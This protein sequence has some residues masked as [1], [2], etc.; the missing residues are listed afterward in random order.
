MDER[1]VVG[2]HSGMPALQNPLP[3]HDRRERPKGA[4]GAEVEKVDQIAILG[5]LC[6]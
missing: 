1:D 3:L 6:F 2:C 5:K 4:V